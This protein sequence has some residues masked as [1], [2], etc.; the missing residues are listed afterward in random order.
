MQFHI[1][2]D[3]DTVTVHADVVKIEVE[4]IVGSDEDDI[5]EHYFRTIRF[6]G[7]H[8][9]SVEVFCSV[10]DNKNVL[11]LHRVKKLKPVKKPKETDWLTPTVSQPT[12]G[13]KKK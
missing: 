11:R 2:T 7:Y 10:Y 12:K 6:V 3:K 1:S 13:K 5:D 9:E 4:D 8:G